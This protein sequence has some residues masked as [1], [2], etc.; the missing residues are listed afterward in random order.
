MILREQLEPPLVFNI[1]STDLVN[2]IKLRA[3]VEAVDFLELLP[4][5]MLL[6]MV[7]RKINLIAH[8]CAITLNQMIKCRA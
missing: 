2:N 3:N 6:K 7:K 8:Q 4:Q 5:S 1:S